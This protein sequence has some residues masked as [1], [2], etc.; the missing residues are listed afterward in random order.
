MV[1][2]DQGCQTMTCAFDAQVKL[3]DVVSYVAETIGQNVAAEALSCCVSSQELDQA[4]SHLRNQ[5]AEACSQKNIRQ[6]TNEMQA[7]MQPA[8]EAA[9]SKIIPEVSW[10]P[11]FEGLYH[12]LHKSSTNCQ[13]QIV[14]MMRSQRMMP[15]RSLAR[16]S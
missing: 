13:C 10:Q 6:S 3:R 1:S 7:L 5:A 15:R 11:V 4:D 12:Q 16:L 9:I 2:A 14:Y 8:A